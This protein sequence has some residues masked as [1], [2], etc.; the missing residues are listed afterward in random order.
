M[1]MTWKA[2]LCSAALVVLGASVAQAMM[3]QD[4]LLCASYLRYTLY[5]EVAAQA[6]ALGAQ[7]SDA[8]RA[9]VEKAAADWSA[10]QIKA[11]RKALT[12]SFG[13]D[14]KA[15]FEQFVK[16][17]TAAEKAGDPA[18]L[19]RLDGDLGLVPAPADYTGL[20]RA[21]VQSLLS[22]DVATGSEWLGNVQTWLDLRTKKPGTPDLD[23]WLGRSEQAAAATGWQFTRSDGTT[24][25]PKKPA[26]DL[27]SA[28]PEMGEYTPPPEDDS[29]PLDTFDT[30]RKERRKKEMEEAQQ[31]MQQVAAER[32]AAEE[33]YASKKRVAAQAEAEALKRQAQDLADVETQA[34]EQR[35]NSFQAKLKEVV[36]GTIKAG[37]GAFTGG[38]GTRAG[39]ELANEVFDDD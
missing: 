5:R 19:A 7:A 17:F 20:R 8:D 15:R 25:T 26:N 9:Q 6:T 3:S 39:E 32:Q 18:F 37:V 2:S 14:A 29:S 21:V 16:D 36:G 34:L 31:G 22:Q 11:V 23:T 33:E 35:K 24:A 38:I 10:G 30:L 1:K 4:A 27:V 12:A 13:Q 28:E